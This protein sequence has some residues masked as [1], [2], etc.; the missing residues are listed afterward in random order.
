MLG[1]LDELKG[2]HFYFHFTLTP[3]G[4]D[5]EGA[6]LPSK[7]ELIQTFRTLSQKI[8]K[9]K[10]I[11]RYDPILLTD[12]IDIEYHKAEFSKL[13]E[14]LKGHTDKCVINFLNRGQ[15]PDTAEDLLKP[16]KIPKKLKGE[17][18]KELYLIGKSC[19]IEIETCRN[20]VNV[21]GLNI[22]PTRCVDA[23]LIGTLIGKKLEIDKDPA[24]RSKACGCAESTEIG[25][26]NTC[27][28]GCL[29]CY[30]TENLKQA[31]L[32]YHL[33]DKN[34]PL[35]IGKIAEDDK[36]NAQQQPKKKASEV[37][38]KGKDTQ[39]PISLNQDWADEG[40]N[41]S[42]GCS[43]DCRYCYAREGQIRKGNK[44][45][46]TWNIEESRPEML[47]K[48]WR[49]TSK[50]KLFPSIHDITPG[51]YENSA[52][53]I[54]NFL[55]PGNFLLIVSKPN[56]DLIGKLC[57]EIKEYKD[58]VLFRF[59]ISATDNDILKFWEPNAPLFEKRLE[60]LKI[61]REKGFETSISVEPML[62]TANIS[63]LIEAVR[64]Y[65]TDSI[66][67]G[68]LNSINRRVKNRNQPEVKKEVEK[69]KSGQVPSNLLEIYNQFKADPL[70]KYKSHI[71]E[72]L[73]ELKII[74][75]KSEDDWRERW[76]AGKA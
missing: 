5:I 57:D 71:R 35:L 21:P 47:D 73:K 38:A 12:K 42:T 55:A 26:D 33:H 17:I 66:W 48:A 72:A 15:M 18:A 51:T 64:P 19:G 24:L 62:D 28:N 37:K 2:Y 45:L 31:R 54:K 39:K 65:T 60:A 4:Q 58:K 6:V 30:A 22:N 40:I 43:N 16:K 29:Y 8:G 53:V 69:I 3:Y 61:A 9:D 68:T 36:N 74:V 13:A 1:R 49:K 67:L 56:P 59:T 46:A 11:W 34:S 41:V 27:V 23:E 50:R 76:A 70:I 75:P 7:D 52:K 32:N 63:A 44:T 10:V 25:M 14:S 20:K